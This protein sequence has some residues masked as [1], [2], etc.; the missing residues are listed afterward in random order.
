[1]EKYKDLK[2][3][4]VDQ[5]EQRKRQ[6]FENQQNNPKSDRLITKFKKRIKDILT[7]LC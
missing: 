6:I 5:K 7:E 2:L 1:M 4:E 3:R